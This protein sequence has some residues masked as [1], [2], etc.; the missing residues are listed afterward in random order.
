[1]VQAETRAGVT[2]AARAG[3]VAFR[4][5]AGAM[6]AVLRRAAIINAAL[7]KLCMLDLAGLPI[8]DYHRVIDAAIATMEQA[9]SVGVVRMVEKQIALDTQRH[10]RAQEEM[11]HAREDEFT[12]TVSLLTDAVVQFRDT[13]TDFTDQVVARSDRMGHMIQAADLRTLRSKLEHELAEL[14]NAAIERQQADAHHLSALGA[15]VKSL[16]SKLAVAVV[17]ASRDGLTGLANRAA[18][19]ERMAELDQQLEGGDYAVALA[20]IDMDHFK[21]VNDQ[22]GHA[23]G[24]ETLQTFARFS[25]TAL[26]GEGFIARYGG[27]EFAALLPAP[28]LEQAVERLTLLLD[29]IRRNKRRRARQQPQLHDQHRRR[30]RHPARHRPTLAQPR[31]PRPLRRQARGPRPHDHH[32]GVTSPDRSPVVG[33]R[34]RTRRRTTPGPPDRT[35]DPRHVLRGSSVLAAIRSFRAARR[36]W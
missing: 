33:G 13:S 14:R 22:F 15:R 31:R 3:E 28:S 25:R 11:L 7:L 17:Q 30:L 27:D 35:A 24:D 1:M 23:A 16:E 26:S 21:Q 6:E 5:D 18:W 2:Q 10:L 29:L 34:R 4:A 20:M 12:K 32:G 9:K 19:D 36:S 8:A